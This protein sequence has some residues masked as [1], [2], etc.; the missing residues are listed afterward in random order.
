MAMTGAEVILFLVFIGTTGISIIFYILFG[1]WTNG[2]TELMNRVMNKTDVIVYNGAGQGKLF[3]IKQQI[4]GVLHH[5]KLGEIIVYKNSH[6]VDQG[7][8][9][10]RYNVFA[11]HGVT[12]P[13]WM[14]SVLEKLNER[15]KTTLSRAEFVKRAIHDRKFLIDVGTKIK[16]PLHTTFSLNDFTEYLRGS[17][18]GNAIQRLVHHNVSQQL[19]LQKKSREILIYAGIFLVIAAVAVLIFMKSFADKDT[20][21]CVF[22]NAPDSTGTVQNIVSNATVTTQEGSNFRGLTDSFGALT[23]QPG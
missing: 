6:Y 12:V 17:M 14:Q 10:V 1:I 8:G 18:S 4:P 7:T 5:K 9:R 19:S 20:I 22:P 23:P 16:V 15:L 21:Q 3:G 2:W 11:P 13:I